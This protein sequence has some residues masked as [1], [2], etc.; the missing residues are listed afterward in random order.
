MRYLQYL[1]RPLRILAEPFEVFLAV[2]ALLSG[3]AVL[4]GATRPVA[5]QSQITPWVLR[6]WGA[7]LLSGGS[8]T[9][10]ARTLMARARTHDQ[11]ETAARIEKLGMILFATTAAM[12]GTAIVAIGRAGLAIGPITLGWAAACAARAWIIS[13]E[14]KAYEDA[15]RQ[16]RQIET[17]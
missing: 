16:A 11:L 6:A 2:S 15:R 14:W 7:A 4:F 1:P 9:L 3:A 12:Y 8:L 17:G 13:R 5:L 10:V